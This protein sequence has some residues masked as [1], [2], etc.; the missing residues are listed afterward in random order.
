MVM[1]T[2]VKMPKLTWTMEEGIVGEWHKTVGE[3][4]DKGTTLCEIETEKS[5]DELRAPESGVLR[6]VLY[7]K[8]SVVKVN[9]LIAVI[10]A[11]DEPLPDEIVTEVQEKTLSQKTFEST[12]EDTAK[13]SAPE[14][15]RPM[16]SPVADKLTEEQGTD[17]IQIRATVAES[18]MI[19]ENVSKTVEQAS[20]TKT[21]PLNRM[22][23]TIRKRLSLSIKNALHVPL[24]MEIDMNEAIRLIQNSQTDPETHLTPTSVIVKA[25]AD[26]LEVHPTLNARLMNDKIEIPDEINIGVAVAIEGG[27]VV[28]VV[29]NANKKTLSAIGKEIA[30]LAEKARTE[31]LIAAES[32]GGTFTVS[33][34]GMFGIDFFAPI[35][36][37]PESAIL[38]V[39]RIAKKPVVIKDEVWPRS[40]MTLTLVFDHRIMDG[41]VAARFL[42]TVKEKLEKPGTL[43]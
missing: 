36:N 7:P 18:S 5:V 6:K 12:S 40:M 42:Q 38:G 21:V 8:G 28:P 23:E 15:Y 4:V 34:L 20:N 14:I 26:A 13:T 32:A 31:T 1:V 43:Q 22:R 35:I 33:N 9:E 37:P 25:I 39:G 41:A 2:L 29:H 11:A 16:V 30:W 24:T 17:S 27:L 19:R 3:Y 10:A